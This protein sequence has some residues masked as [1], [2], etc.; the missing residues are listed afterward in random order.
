MLLLWI[1]SQNIINEFKGRRTTS[2]GKESQVSAV[3][4]VPI[5]NVTKTKLQKLGHTL[6]YKGKIKP[7]L[8]AK[9]TTKGRNI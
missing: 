4:F 6:N 1:Q 9:W 8:H 3:V 5:P 2:K 7:C